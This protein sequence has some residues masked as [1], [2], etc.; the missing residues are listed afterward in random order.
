MAS[1]PNYILLVLSAVRRQLQKYLLVIIWETDGT[2][3][4]L[5]IATMI[6]GLGMMSIISKERIVLCTTVEGM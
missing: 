3:D 1:G 4:G 2:S 6:W 5:A